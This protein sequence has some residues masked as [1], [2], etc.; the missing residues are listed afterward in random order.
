M[1]HWFGERALEIMGEDFVQQFKEKYET[2][3]GHVHLAAST[4]EAAD[5]VVSILRDTE[6][7]RVALGELPEAFRGSLEQRC[8]EAGMD[9]LKPPFKSAELPRAI[10]SAQVGVSW[11]AFVIAET[12]T[13]VEF[14]K[15]DALRLVS[16][17][18]EVHVGVFCAEDLVETLREAAPP[19]R[20]FYAE[21]PRNATVTFISGP[22]RTADIE[23][24]L[25]LGVH[26]P[27]VAHA[28][29]IGGER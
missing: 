15:D 9:V 16:T 28:V 21:N 23:M 14:A 29:V 3:A 10:D 17:L 19:I 4:T 7:K 6:A 13:L 25:T 27:A 12:G 2:L 5:V 22:S 24:R 8:I 1:R 26:G 11:P 20:D 18:P